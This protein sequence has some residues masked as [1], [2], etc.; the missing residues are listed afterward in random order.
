MLATFNLDGYNSYSGCDIIVTAS[1]PLVNGQSVGKY[2]S[3]GSLQTLS[4]STHQDKR[5]VRSLGV[6][7]AK[8]YVMGPR[9]IAGSMVF[10]V[11][12]K[13][14]ATSIMEDLGEVLLPD[15]IPALD[16]TVSFANE[17]GKKSRMA[18][19]GVKFINE[20]QVMSINDLYTENTYQFVALGLEP[21][22]A[23]GED[24]GKTITSFKKKNASILK[25]ESSVTNP[26]NKEESGGVLSDK[27]KNNQG[28]V[29]P[30]PDSND[31]YPSTNT[32]NISNNTIKQ[33]ILSV[34]TESAKSENDLGLVTFEITPKR[35][36]GHINIYKGSDKKENADYILA[37]T[38]ASSKYSLSLGKGGYI[39]QYIDHTL[40]IK[41]DVVGFNIETDVKLSFTDNLNKVSP[42][43]DKLT[44][45]SLTIS[46]NDNKYDTLN[47]L[48]KGG[49]VKSVFFNDKATLTNLQPD[50]VYDLY[51][52][53]SKTG[54]K[55]DSVYVK[56][57]EVG[58]TEEEFFKA[59]VID[60]SNLLINDKE[61]VI[62]TI[63][64]LSTTSENT[65]VKRNIDL[66]TNIKLNYN[67]SII[68]A[69]FNLT[70]TS[71]KQELMIFAS[72][73][74]DNLSIYR[75]LHCK[76]YISNTALRNPFST[77]VNSIGYNDAYVYEHKNNKKSL[78]YIIDSSSNC[79]YAKP[80]KL[81]S[82]SGIIDNKEQTCPRYFITCRNYY[83]DHLCA[84]TKTEQYKLLDTTLNSLKY[85]TY[86]NQAIIDL[87]IKENFYC[88]MELIKP[89]YAYISDNNHVVVDVNYNELNND[90]K[91]YVACVD[92]Y[93][94]LDY[95][96]FHKIK[97]D[98]STKLIDMYDNYIG[99]IPGNKYLFWIED[100]NCYKISKPFIFEYTQDEDT[101][102]KDMYLKF[103][104]KDLDNIKRDL[105]KRFP[106]NLVLEE[107]FQYLCSITLPEKNM[108]S[109][110]ILEVIRYCTNSKY[111]FNTVDVLFEL[112]KIIHNSNKIYIDYP[113][114]FDKI[115]RKIKFDKYDDY[116]IKA[117]NFTDNEV[118]EIYEDNKSISYG[119]EGY[120]IVYLVKNNLLE[121][122]SFILIDCK[123]NTYIS[124]NDMIDYISEGV[125]D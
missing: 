30:S 17:Y 87:T 85:N 55:T 122:S 78:V 13:H 33:I 84:Y 61:E 68:D 4:I 124:T 110:V 31:L 69:I 65:D 76:H 40:S 37:V 77:Q 48:Y 8:D 105:L 2:Y 101:E 71:I 90:K 57:F 107:C 15:E 125:V 92:L 86:S 81:Y 111:E 5:P 79:F 26:N 70:D 22:N 34:T 49:S 38:D 74:L 18:I 103:M 60:N 3:L 27:I 24:S 21:L 16:I 9:T 116:N 73:L 23:D 72:R 42:I 19:Y 82:I 10:A 100:E 25:G 89:P 99:L 80:N 97:F 64:S 115:N 54:E 117:L 104:K 28:L 98:S 88:D 41:S 94:A 45:T 44:D 63:N 29:N 113:I 36:E 6:I 58:Q 14:F 121:R 51:F 66:D 12:N 93:E 91:Y 56:T 52:S 114:T 112:L 20:G 108:F 53:S 120:T 109:T 50:T 62:N 39:A 106:N 1:L 123:N 75:N 11:F 43:I 35:M 7:N 118:T 47:Y 119:D 95:V 102:I 46:L 59:F 67:S 83:V 32:G 96:P